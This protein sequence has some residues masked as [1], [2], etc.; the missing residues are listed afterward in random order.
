MHIRIMVY[1]PVNTSP[2]LGSHGRLRT[3]LRSSL[4]RTCTAPE[5]HGA[6]SYAARS[7]TGPMT[8]SPVT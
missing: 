5:S 2:I 7:Q 4:S 6:Q 1:P 8:A 3:T